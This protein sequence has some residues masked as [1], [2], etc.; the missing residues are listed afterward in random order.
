MVEDGVKIGLEIHVQMTSLK[1]KLFCSCS[2]DYRGA[3]PNTHVCPVCLGLP[4]SLPV[5]NKEAIKKALA[6]ALALNMEISSRVCWA[7]KH[8]FY[9]DLPKNYQITQ[10]EGKGTTSF[11]KN[12]RLEINVDGEK[13]V[14]RIRRINIEEDPGRIVY[15]TGS[16][17]TSPYVLVDYNRSGIALLEIVTEP[18]FRDEREVVA[19]LKKLR[20]L[21]EHLDVTDFSLEGS[22]RADVNISI[23]GGPRVEVKNIG[24]ITEIEKAIRY[25]IARQRAMLARGESVRME[26]RHWDPERKVTVAVRMK[27][28]EEDYRYMPDPNLPSIEITSEIINEVKNSMPELP[29]ERAARYVREHG[30]S[31]YLASV[32]VSRKALCDYFDEVLKR[33]SIEPEK[34]AAYI[35][36]DLLGWIP[37][38]DPRK[39][40]SLIPPE[41]TAKVLNMLVKRRITIKMA[42]EMIPLMLKG[43]EPEEIVKKMG[44]EVLRDERE[45]ERI[46]MEVF[47]ENPKAVEDARRNKKAI[48]F[49]VGQVLRKTDKKADPKIV[50]EVIVRMLR[51][52]E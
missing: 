42:K 20:S 24:S 18:D 31:E 4:G 37:E 26:T 39:L 8:Y 11:A 48:Q 38:E 41:R 29:E 2:S 44:W 33:T 28:T 3:P 45:I 22:M 47:N 46:V 52:K 27:E 5:V 12:G 50:Y 36:N 43:E 23:A 10:Y 51:E 40:W 30:V 1:T 9:P 35:V 34:A 49:L 13:K 7:R 17:L 6:V 14:V 21:L 32:L 16:M 19:F 15:P 25:E